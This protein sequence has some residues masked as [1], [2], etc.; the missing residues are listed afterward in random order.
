MAAGV[1]PVG[2]AVGA[3]GGSVGWLGWWFGGCA[4]GC[5]RGFGGGAAVGRRA[6]CVIGSGCCGDASERSERARGNVCGLW[7]TV[8]GKQGGGGRPC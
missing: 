5:L 8:E 3:G 1:E 6:V 7:R 2:R 4:G